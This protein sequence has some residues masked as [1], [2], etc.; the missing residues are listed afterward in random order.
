M[1][2][3]LVEGQKYTTDKLEK[4]IIQTIVKDSPILSRLKFMNWEGNSYTYNRESTEP[5]AQFYAVGDTW[6]EST[7]TLTQV[8]AVLYTLGGDADVDNFLQ[9]TKGDLNDIL[10]MQVEA[11]TEAVK[12]KYHDGYYYGSNAA[13]SKSPDG[14]HILIADATYNTVHAGSGTGTA[15]SIDKLRQAMDMIKGQSPDLIVSSKTMRRRMTTYMES[16]GSAFPTTRDEFGMGVT[17]FNGTPWATDDN[18]VDTET[19][20][21]GAY[22]AQTG[23]ANTSIFV[24][25]FDS[26]GVMGLQ[27]GSLKTEIFPRLETKNASR[28]R[29]IWY[30]SLML[31]SLISCAKVDGIVA[32]SAVTAS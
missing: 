23:G 13:D 11:K 20:A 9:Q 30:V 14:C 19:A 17:D 10:Q 31:K 16:V 32:A 18:I 15:L 3:T 27:N 2:L 7:G 22:A 12:R 8:T 29:I 6:T 5:T 25:R 4:G 28:V 24:F 26:L 21:S 1:S